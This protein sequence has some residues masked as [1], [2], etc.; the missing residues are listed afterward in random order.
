[1]N[2]I[3]QLVARRRLER[4]LAEEIDQHLAE[5]V[6]ALVAA[7]VSR[8]E[9]R[10]AARRAF[11]NVTLAQERSRDVWHWASIEDVWADLR[12]GARQLR[13]TPSFA[14]AAIVTLAMGI[15]VNTAV[16]SLVYAIVLKP[17]DFPEPDHVVAVESLD[18]RDRPH[19]TSLSYHTFFEFR[20]ASVF[21]RMA[22]YRETGMTLTG[23]SVPVQLDGQIVSCDFFDALGVRPALGR[24]FLPSDEQPGARVVVLGH[25]VWVSLFGADPDIVDRP[26]SIGGEPFT[27][28]GVAPAGFAFPIRDRPVQIWTTLAV[29]ASSSATTV[30]P[31]AEQRGARVLDA[32]ARL[33]RGM[34]IEEAHARIDA[35]AADLARREPDTNKNQPA[36]YVKPELERMLGPTREPMLILWGAVALVLLIACANI[37]N[38][39]L[40]RTTDRERE[41]AVRLAIG[42]SRARVVR[43][44]LTENLLLAVVGG[45][46]GVLVAVS[47]IRLVVPVVLERLPRAGD[48][49]VDASVLAFTLTLVLITSVLVSIPVALWVRRLDVSPSRSGTSRG[50]TDSHDHV[51]STLVVAQLSVGLVLMSGASLLAASFV[52]LMQREVGFR[53]EGLL[54]FS[55]SLPGARYTNEAQVDLIGRLLDRLNAMPGVS[56]AA[57]GMPLPLEGNEMNVAFDIVGRPAP[58]SRRPRSNMAFVTPGYFAT[59]GTPVL[60]GRAFTEQDDERHQPVLI[61]NEAFADRFFPGERALGKRIE[62]GATSVAEARRG[63]PRVREIVGI[64]GNAHQDP[65]G[66]APEPI[67]YFPYKQLTWGPPSLIVRTSIEG[68]TIESDFRKLVASLEPD[69]PVHGVRTFGRMKSVG[70]AVPRLLALLMGTFAGTALLLTATGLYG[71]LAYAVMR[72][73]REIGVRLALGATRGLIVAMV[74]KRALLLIAIGVPLGTAGAF[75]AQTLLRKVVFSPQEGGPS[76]VLVAAIFIVT[77][78]AIAA[79]SFPAMRAASIDPVQA[80]RSE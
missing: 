8:R 66:R 30:T 54:R 80:L 39:L 34:S 21:E 1:M 26:V 49:G 77:L 68:T 38:M 2:W 37:A 18:I 50:A 47:L 6:D 55:I 14:A 65:L 32:V 57:A 62:S 13:R 52:Y 79:A 41:L 25:D 59:I 27:V 78:T 20:R 24:G 23:R 45:A 69:A 64:V 73:T 71:V 75:A 33:K 46:A 40:A 15:G 61:V 35:V 67:Y 19:P 58:S 22:S 70:I 53:P 7:G 42:G 4:D 10:V 56:K 11:G 36:T 16:F 72:R 74:L 28:V 48:V 43:Q 60:E 29:D 44:L 76:L 63:G 9:A 51:R 31:M 3:R 12:Y 17:L 5:K